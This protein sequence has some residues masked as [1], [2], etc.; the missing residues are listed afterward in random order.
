MLPTSCR[1]RRSAWCVSAAPGL[2]GGCVGLVIAER[3][4]SSVFEQNKDIDRDPGQAHALGARG[5]VSKSIA[6]A[7]IALKAA[8]SD[9]SVVVN[10]RP[11]SARRITPLHP[12]LALPVSIFGDSAG[13]EIADLR[14]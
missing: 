11:K 5:T 1:F 7:H 8:R 13:T 2:A 12:A 6:A 3:L 10:R 9:R 14:E 4:P